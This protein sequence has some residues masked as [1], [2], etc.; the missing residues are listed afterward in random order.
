M[1]FRVL[2]QVHPGLV[3]QDGDGFVIITTVSDKGM[4]DIYNRKLQ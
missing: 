1:F 4:V 3:P 2:A